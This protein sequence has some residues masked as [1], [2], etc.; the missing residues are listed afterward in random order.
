MSTPSVKK[1]DKPFL[2]SVL[3]LVGAGIGIFSSASLGLLARTETIFKSVVVNQ[4]GLGLVGGLIAMCVI[5]SINYKHLKKYAFFFYIAAIILLILVFVPGI[6]FAHGG[7]R[8]WIHVGNLF[9]IQPS[10]IY[11]VAF[12][13]FFAFWLSK[14]KHQVSTFKYG[15][16]AFLV[17]SLESQNAKK[18]TNATL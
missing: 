18:S 4:I 16:S 11:K 10:E 13:L 8:R 15:T 2:I 6:G 5:A 14:L 3:L 1:I 7:A 12:V 9:S 17:L